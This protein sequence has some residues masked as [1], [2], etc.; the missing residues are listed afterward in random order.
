MHRDSRAGPG[1]PSAYRRDLAS[2]TG[3]HARTA[4]QGA[5]GDHASRY[6][7]EIRKET[8]YFEEIP[9]V[10][11]PDEMT[12]L[13]EHILDSKAGHFDPG[14]FKARYEECGRGNAPSKAGR[15]APEARDRYTPK[16]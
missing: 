4:Q 8:E 2:R 7:Y 12:K 11:L 9:S 1:R 16:M 5:I 3:R 6:A 15:H 10:R 13:S 14:E